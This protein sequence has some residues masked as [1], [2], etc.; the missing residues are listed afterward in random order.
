MC[1][2]ALSACVA[3]SLLGCATTTL[4]SGE[5]PGRTAAGYD[6]RWHGGFLFGT[7]RDVDGYQLGQVCPKGWAEIRV[8]ADP[9]T[10]LAGM[11]TL[12]MYSPSRV[13]VVCAR[14]PGDEELSF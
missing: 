1:R 12:F 5:P 3:L 11:L 14:Q 10:I 9:F 8:E 7:V 13:T 4:R 6:E 2:R